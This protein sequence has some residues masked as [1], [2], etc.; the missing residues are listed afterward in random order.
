MSEYQEVDNIEISSTKKFD[1]IICETE[2]RIE[3]CQHHKIPLDAREFEQFKK[4]WFFHY[5]HHRFARLGNVGVI[6]IPNTTLEEWIYWLYEWSIK[7]TDDYNKFKK[8]VF[9][10]IK[11]HEEHLN[12]L[13][14]KVKDLEERVTELERQVQ[15]IWQKINEILEQINQIWSKINEMQNTINSLQQ[16]INEL[17][18]NN[19]KLNKIIQN[20]TESGAWNPN[21]NDFYPDRDIATGNINF[22][23]GSQ[24]GGSF[25]RTN[26]GHTENDVTAGI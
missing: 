18:A 25:I 21:T 13:D 23:G 8:L 4:S 26:N 1:D 17:K 2:R 12:I 11:L 10:A 20:L 15:L 16:Q 9:E 3:E 7:F 14:N 19:E 5:W 22:F 24:D 6:S